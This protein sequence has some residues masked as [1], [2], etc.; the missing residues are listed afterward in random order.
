MV[1]GG[2]NR[3]PPYAATITAKNL[4]LG[5]GQPHHF[6]PFWIRIGNPSRRGV[7]CHHERA[8]VVYRLWLAGRVRGLFNGGIVKTV[9]FLTAVAS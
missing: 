4:F 7:A 1:C 5:A 6:R 9:Y 3:S 8:A 2:M